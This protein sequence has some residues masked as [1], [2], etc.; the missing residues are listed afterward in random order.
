MD[1][2]LPTDFALLWPVHRLVGGVE[3]AAF[4]G[5]R[6]GDDAELGKLRRHVVPGLIPGTYYLQAQRVRRWVA[7]Q[8][9]EM[10]RRE[11]VDVLLMAPVPG[12][13]PEGLK[14]TGP[15]ELMQP[16]A[17]LGWPAMTINGG[18]SSNGL[19]LGIQMVAGFGRTGN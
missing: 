11:G 19:P 3:G 12:P 13:A 1:V 17:T 6:T 2:Q 8:M 4:H 9:D 15:P 14:S 18:M 5:A 10:L 16:W 7:G